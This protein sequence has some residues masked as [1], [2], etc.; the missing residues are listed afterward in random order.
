MDIKISR[1][2]TLTAENGHKHEIEYLLFSEPGDGLEHYGVA[3]ISRTRNEREHIRDVTT[4]PDKIAELYELL[5]RNTVTP[6]TVRDVV[7]DWLEND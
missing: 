5:V 2:I 4:L 7:R 6:A 1:A 3:L